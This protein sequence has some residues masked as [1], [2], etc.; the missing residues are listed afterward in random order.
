MDDLLLVYNKEIKE[1][2]EQFKKLKEEGSIDEDKLSSDVKVAKDNARIRKF[3]IEADDKEADV[4]KK[5][6]ENVYSPELELAKIDNEKSKHKLEETKNA[7]EINKNN[8]EKSLDQMK[9]QF[10]D[11]KLK[12]EL[13]IL[14]QR[15]E[16]DLQIQKDHDV[17]NKKL[18]ALKDEIE[19]H[20]KNEEKK[21]VELEDS[22]TNKNR[23]LQLD[24]LKDDVEVQKLN[25]QLK[26]LKRQSELNYDNA[27][28]KIQKEEEAIKKQIEEVCKFPKYWM[29][30]WCGY[31]LYTIMIVVIFLLYKSIVSHLSLQLIS[32]I[33]IITILLII[34]VVSMI[35][36]IRSYNR[37]CINKQKAKEYYEA[38]I[39]ALYERRIKI[40]DKEL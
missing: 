19:W 28:E 11:E 15:C 27:I 33:V 2:K 5:K 7:K 1:L 39:R 36:F 35:Y 40:L 16:I 34:W 26:E 12:H 8:N 3:K 14:Q 9:F 30:V 20:K 17:A 31:S 21:I 6:I 22:Y 24:K 37:Y 13:A 18:E 32:I 29:G 23:Q 38:M 25:N 10:E 4:N